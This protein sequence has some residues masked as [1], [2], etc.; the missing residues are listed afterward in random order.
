MSTDGPQI[1]DIRRRVHFELQTLRGAIGYLEKLS[2]TAAA[3]ALVDAF[4]RPMKN[5]E[6]CCSWAEVCGNCGL[7]WQPDSSGGYCRRCGHHKSCHRRRIRAED[8]ADGQASTEPQ[9]EHVEQPVEAPAASEPAA[10]TEG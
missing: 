10:T 8:Q 3:K 5:G 4:I 1:L 6:E 7:E 2:Y 9:T